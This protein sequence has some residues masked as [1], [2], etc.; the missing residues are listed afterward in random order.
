MRRCAGT[1]ILLFGIYLLVAHAR[2]L[3]G[4]PFADNPWTSILYSS[5]GLLL[6]PFGGL[7]LLLN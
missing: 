6:L 4:G 3:I 5:F 2:V 1:L 7:M